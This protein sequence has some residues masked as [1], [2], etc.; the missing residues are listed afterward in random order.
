MK[1]RIA[2][3]L[4]IVMMFCIFL[5]A[6][7]SGDS[8]NEVSTPGGQENASE[9][10]AYKEISV[11]SYGVVWAGTLDAC[12]MD[13]QVN[14]F[15]IYNLTYDCMFRPDSSGEIV[16]DIF[17]SWEWSDD[18]LTLTCR[19]YDDIYFSNGEQMVG[20]DVIYSIA[21]RTAGPTGGWYRCINTDASTVSDDGL[22]VELKYDYTFGPGIHKLNI[23]VMDKSFVESLGS[24]PDWYDPANLVGSGPYK[25]TDYTK[26]YGVTFEL[27][28]DYWG[29]GDFDADKINVYQYTDQTTMMIDVESGKLDIAIGTSE[30]DTSVAMD[31]GID[32]VV[33]DVIKSNSV[34]LLNL[35]DESPK[36]QDKAVREAICLSVNTE[37]MTAASYGV[38]GITA[39]SPYATDLLGYEDGHTYEYNPEKARQILADAGYKDGDIELFFL[40]ANTTELYAI[41]ETLQSYLSEI[42]INLTVESG[43]IA[44]V[45]GIIREDPLASDFIINRQMDGIPDGEPWFSIYVYGDN[46]VFPQSARQNDPELQEYLDVLEF[47]LD[48]DARIQASKAVQAYLIDN[49][50]CIPICEFGTGIAYRSDT[51]SAPN[52]ISDTM[53]NLRY[54]KLV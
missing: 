41:A 27:R 30:I 2:L 48:E 51:V 7:K 19:L 24:E 18:Y 1:K 13:T 39:T 3:A 6:C 52:I 11:G 23:Y 26:D 22:T 33:G 8:E 25:V 20:E 31:G 32:K 14:S 5:S 43:S 46:Y 16:S 21:R 12:A 45:N 36:L 29:N 17:E 40:S 47:S 9:V 44:T 28:D 38:L 34:V 35:S 50:I 54:V 15:G 37:E 42:G 49:Y 4:A 53:T 10:S